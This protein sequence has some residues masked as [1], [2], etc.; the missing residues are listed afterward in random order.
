MLDRYVG[1][2]AVDRGI[3]VYPDIDF[4]TNP[5]A[6]CN[7]E[8]TNELRWVLGMLEWDRVQ[9]YVDLNSGWEYLDQLKKFVDEGMVDEE[10]VNGVI[11]IVTRNCHDDS[12]GDRR[13]L[14]EENDVFEGSRLD[15]FRR[16]VFEIFNLPLTYRP[17]E[18]PSTSP[19]WFPTL[20]PS[21]TVTQRPIQ[22]PT[23]QPTIT[24]KAGKGNGILEALPPNSA[25]RWRPFDPFTLFTF[26]LFLW[27]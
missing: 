9:S 15:N 14:D 22:Q 17:T 5:E 4:C 18:S 10:F 2:G 6:I 25:Q 8:R 24:E 21:V 3:Y 13:H 1:Q 20:T 7:H 19:T 23:Q 16:I 27:N 12:C 11:N 26:A